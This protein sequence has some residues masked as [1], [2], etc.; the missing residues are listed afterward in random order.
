MS[1]DNT[2]PVIAVA[3]EE[4]IEGGEEIY[5]FDDG[6]RVKLTSIP[7]AVIDNVVS[8]I[9]MPEVPMV[10]LPDYDRDEPNPNDPAYLLAVQETE[11]KR[12]GAMI[13]AVVMFGIQLVDGMPTTDEWLNKLRFMVDHGIMS[14]EGYDL[15]KLTPVEKEFVYKRYSA[16]MWMITRVQEL[17]AVA[18]GD[19]DRA[20]RLFRGTPKK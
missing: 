10:R 7:A 3:E 16:P 19:I 18:K 17:S 2:N 6:N 12:G 8:R 14:M 15:N 13:D 1:D 4:S 20:K 9:K 11:R 5:A